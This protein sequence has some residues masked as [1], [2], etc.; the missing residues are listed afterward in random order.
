MRNHKY[1]AELKL[2]IPEW[3]MYKEG[4]VETFWFDLLNESNGLVRYG[5]GKQWEVVEWDEYIGLEDVDGDNLY[6]NDRVYFTTV[7]T[8]DSKGGESYSG[9]ITWDEE[10]TGFFIDNDN[11]KYPHVKLWFATNIKII[12]SEK[13]KN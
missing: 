7:K 4:D 6:E 12:K 1:R 10:D 2:V 3:G 11:D 9:T 13:W 5:I 8:F